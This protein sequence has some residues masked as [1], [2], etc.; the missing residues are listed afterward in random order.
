MKL[1]VASSWRNPHQPSVVNALRSA[2]HECY[3]F[4]NPPNRAGF[5]WRDVG[6]EG[7]AIDGP[8]MRAALSHPDAKAGFEADFLGMRWADGCV[9]VLPCG[10]SA[11]LEAGFMA[12]AGKPVFVLWPPTPE[13]PDLMYRMTQGVFDSV[14]EIILA[15]AGGWT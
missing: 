12:G 10:R 4:R 13:G 5:Q 14:E 6:I 7:T 15:I 3:D 8:G 9:L 11:H 1:Y 2:G